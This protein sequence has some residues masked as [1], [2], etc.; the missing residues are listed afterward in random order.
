MGEFLSLWRGLDVNGKT[1]KAEV[2]YKPDID[3]S[4]IVLN[5]GEKKRDCV[6]TPFEVSKK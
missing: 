4:N 3:V 2:N 1:M 5:D 6:L